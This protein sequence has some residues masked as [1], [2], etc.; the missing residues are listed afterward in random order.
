MLCFN[1]NFATCKLGQIAMGEYRASIEWHRNEATFSDN[2]YSR[3]HRWRFDGGLEIPASS[4]PHIVPLPMSVESAVDP[5]EA[6]V[7]SLASC[8]MLWFLAIAQQHG[9]V[10]DSYRDDAIGELAKNAEGKLAMTRVTL[11]PCV[12]F[13]GSAP[14]DAATINRMHDDA[15]AQCFIANSV[16]TDV[17]CEPIMAIADDIDG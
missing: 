9:L 2:H 5:E 7:A 14:P 16:R 17:C 3:G 1:A 15:H 8:H 13:S 11:R 4:S 6:F 12:E 10:V